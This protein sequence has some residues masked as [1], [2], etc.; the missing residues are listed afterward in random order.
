MSPVVGNFVR[1]LV[2]MAKAMEELPLAQAELDRLRKLVDDQ[3]AIIARREETILKLKADADSLNE[4]VRA[5]EASRDDAELRFLEADDHITAFRRLVSTFT[6]D[7]VS[8]LRAIE[9]PKP[10][11]VAEPIVDHADEA[12]AA[13]PYEWPSSTQAD[14]SATDPTATSPVTSESPYAEP[15]APASDNAAGVT[16]E[17]VS[18]QPDPSDSPVSSTSPSIPTIASSPDAD[19]PAFVPVDDVGYHNEPVQ[20]SSEWYHWRDRMDTRYGNGWWPK[21]SVA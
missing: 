14:Q 11:P 2:D 8:L 18:V 21:R 16:T 6:T 12:S 17:G 4:K 13:S 5:A 7:T 19:I 20:Y 1:D 15:I 9:P 10:E 3:G